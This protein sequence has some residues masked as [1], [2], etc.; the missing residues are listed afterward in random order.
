L[1]ALEKNVTRVQLKGESVRV[2][3]PL[4]AEEASHHC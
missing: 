1:R 3:D 2:L 4:G